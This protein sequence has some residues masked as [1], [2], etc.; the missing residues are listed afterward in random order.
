M[1]GKFGLMI[2]KLAFG[3]SLT[4]KTKV[5]IA[6]EEGASAEREAIIEELISFR[7]SLDL[8]CGGI[9]EIP[10]STGQLLDSQL[11][12]VIEYLESRRPKSSLQNIKDIE[13]SP[14]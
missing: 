5:E 14:F 4:R 3:L 12:Q 8:A 7:K 10:G 9:Q 6:R 13:W 11:L 1:S 2:P